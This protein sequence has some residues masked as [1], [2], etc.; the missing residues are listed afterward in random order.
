MVR[1]FDEWDENV[2]HVV[3]ANRELVEAEIRLRRQVAEARRAGRSWAAIAFAL[4]V[5]E[6]T[7]EQRFGR[8]DGRT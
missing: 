3:T 5:T 4:G 2:N 6:K 7:A 8:W 1:R